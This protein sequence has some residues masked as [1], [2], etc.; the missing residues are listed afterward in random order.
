MILCGERCHTFRTSVPRISGGDPE[1]AE[2]AKIIRKEVHAIMDELSNYQY[3]PKKYEDR[4][5]ER[6][7]WDIED[8]DV[9]EDF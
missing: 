8:G 6:R 2:I 5:R 1:P 3:D 4:V 9:D 7:N